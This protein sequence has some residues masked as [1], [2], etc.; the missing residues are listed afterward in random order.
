MTN[1]YHTIIP[2][3]QPSHQQQSLQNQ[4]QVAQ[5]SPIHQA[6]G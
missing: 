1:Q 6:S 3:P 5:A 4:D 2:C